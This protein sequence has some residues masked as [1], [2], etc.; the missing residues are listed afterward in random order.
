M[1]AAVVGYI[2][3]VVCVTAF[4]PQAWKVFK[5]RDTKDLSA[6]MWI[7]ETIGFVLW[8]TYGVKLGALPIIIP[9]AICA[10]LSAFILA[11]KLTE[12]RR[13]SG[14]SERRSRSEPAHPRTSPRGTSPPGSS[15]PVAASRSA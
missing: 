13:S 8:V 6:C 7:L 3:A 9:N 10:V 1:S 15:R 11:M 4:V 2:A 14:R 12:S 5:T